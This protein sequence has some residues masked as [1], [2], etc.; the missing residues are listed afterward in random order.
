MQF[1]R[2]LHG[3]YASEYAWTIRRLSIALLRVAYESLYSF[4]AH[5]LVHCIMNLSLFFFFCTLFILELTKVYA[6]CL[7]LDPLLLCP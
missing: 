1:S 7:I 5:Q 3:G 2:A 4:N 6:E